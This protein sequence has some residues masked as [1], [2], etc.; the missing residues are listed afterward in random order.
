MFELPVYFRETRL[1]LQR[2]S[3]LS[4]CN[5][6]GLIAFADSY[7]LKNPETYRLGSIALKGCGR[8]IDIYTVYA[9]SSLVIL[10][11]DLKI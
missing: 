10:Q 9:V 1:A 3:L 4:V 8:E 7:L 6:Y 5:K 11:L 2:L